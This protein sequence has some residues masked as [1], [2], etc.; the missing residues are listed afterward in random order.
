MLPRET[1]NRRDRGIALIVV[2][3]SMTLLLALG[4]TLVLTA[5]LETRIPVHYRDGAEAL[6]AADAAIERA[7]S[8]LQLEPDWNGILTGTTVSSFVDGPPSGTRTLAGT[9][10]NL[11]EQTSLVRCGRRSGCTE[12]EMNAASTDRPWGRNNP[13]WQLYL[14]GPLTSLPSVHTIR[15]SAYIMV[16]VAD[17]P[18][19]TDDD[20]LT[21]GG[22]PVGD[23]DGD[24]PGRGVLSLRAHAYGPSGVRRIVRATVER[25]EFGDDELPGSLRVVSWREGD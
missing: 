3:M 19:E 2:L 17:D 10:L 13:R 21:D 16:W 20:W 22:P 25:L 8:D 23:P 1:C 12:D 4:G 5:T 9:T 14:Y 7:L 15:S 24:N 6:Y 11:D 18:S